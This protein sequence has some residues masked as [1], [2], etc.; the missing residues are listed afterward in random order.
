MQLAFRGGALRVPGRD[1]GRVDDL[2]AGRDIGRRVAEDGFDPVLAQALQIAGLGSVRAGH[3]S[4]ELP[5]DQRQAAHPG[6]ADADEMQPAAVPVLCRRSQA[7]RLSGR[8][9]HRRATMRSVSLGRG[10]RWLTGGSLVAIALLVAMAAAAGAAG[11]RAPTLRARPAARQQCA[12]PYSAQRDPANPLALATAPGENP[13]TGARFFVDGPAHGAAAGAIAQLLGLNP[14]SLPDTE[15]WSAFANDFTSGRLHDKLAGNP[16]LA[17]E[18]NQL[19]KI[20]AQPEVQRVSAYSYGG[21][22]G[23]IFA[24]TQ[25]LL[26]HNLLADPGSILILN[27]Y[28]LHPAAGVCP[29]AGALR[30]AAGTFRRHVNEVAAA[31]ANR[32]VL[33][34]LETDAIG[35]SSCIRRHGGLGES[36]GTAALR[37]RKDG[38]RCRMPSSTSRAAMRIPAPPATAPRSSTRSASGGSAA[39]TP[40]TRTST[41]RSTRSAGRPRSRG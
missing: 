38:Q 13:L 10:L 33:M 37:D 30:R 9:S 6:S 29:G 1:R 34:L 15:S 18:V 27:T 16:G 12:D 31:V 2:G 24:Q 5:G 21:R 36:G 14:A 4:A 23:G 28:F 41:G 22:R 40:T 25:K 39:S 19:S 35:T 7:T 26:C 20:A 8:R 32:P 3:R 11:S 17:N